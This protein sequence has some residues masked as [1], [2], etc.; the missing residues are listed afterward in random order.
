MDMFHFTSNS[1]DIKYEI[2]YAAR[3]GITIGSSGLLMTDS[4]PTG[5][6][7]TNDYDLNN[8]KGVNVD[9][10]FIVSCLSIIFPRYFNNYFFSQELTKP[11]FTLE[12]SLSS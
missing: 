10:I 8:S 1:A 9:S 2:T 5:T 7:G 6:F 11:M 3:K 12:T 4:F